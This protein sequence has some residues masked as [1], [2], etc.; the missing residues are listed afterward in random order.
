[1]ESRK[2]IIGK[3]DATLKLL[4]RRIGQ[5]SE[6]A[7]KRIN[8]LPLEQLDELFDAAFDFEKKAALNEWLRKHARA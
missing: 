1:M 5:V 7:Q 8:K 6:A 2:M 3:R 4:T